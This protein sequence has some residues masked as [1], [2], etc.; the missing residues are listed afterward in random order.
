MLPEEF[1]LTIPMFLTPK[2]FTA[3][4]RI[5]LEPDVETCTFSLIPFTLDIQ[6]AYDSAD[7]AIMSK[8]CEGP[9][10]FDEENVF[11]GSP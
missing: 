5:A 9:N 2:C 4:I 6:D 10:A 8:L 7:E 3:S 1:R 11:W